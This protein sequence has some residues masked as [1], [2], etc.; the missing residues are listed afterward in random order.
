MS[1]ALF[2]AAGLL[3]LNWW[4][5]GSPKQSPVPLPVPLPI[6]QLPTVDVNTPRNGFAALLVI[7]AALEQ[8]G[9]TPDEIG[10]LIEPIA[11]LLTRQRPRVEVQA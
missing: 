1:Y 5:G 10:K 4:M 2:A 7:R 8:A 6:D 11:P 9:A 3:L